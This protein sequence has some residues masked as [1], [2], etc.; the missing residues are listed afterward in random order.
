MT[1]GKGVALVLGAGVL[2]SSIGLVVRQI[3]EAGAASVMFWRSAGLL[4][5]LWAFLH[6]RSGGRVL[7]G[8][9][10]VGVPGL[11]G[12]LGLVAA[13]SGAIYSLQ[14]TTVANAVFLYSAAPFFA[15]LLG[16][17]ALGE[18]VPATTWA[19]MGLAGLGIFVMIG[20]GIEGGRM[21]GN[22]AALVSAFGFA[23]F[24]VSLR[25]G[26]VEDSLPTVLLGGILSMVA[27]FGLAPMLGQTVAANGHDIAVSMALGAVVLTGGMA[28]YTF[29]SKALPTAELTL[30]SSIE[31]ILA[32]IWVWLLLG[33]TATP[34]TLMGGAMVLIAVMG[35]AVAGARRQALA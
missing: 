8:L 22:I 14:A 13:Y 20:G 34:A 5:V 12:A 31:N 9:R 18:K 2:W 6:W 16:W 1:Y 30:I 21:D 15:A 35:N 19:A 26:H 3:D 23:V 11:V 27:A 32:P 10:S 33:E 29:G 17:A 28:L 25:W 4:P 24:S 7:A